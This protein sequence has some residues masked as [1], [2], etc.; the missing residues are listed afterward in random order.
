MPTKTKSR[1]E[2]FQVPIHKNLTREDVAG[3]ERIMRE[4][5]DKQHLGKF[6]SVKDITIR[7]PAVRRY[8]ECKGSEETYSGIFKVPV[9]RDLLGRLM[10]D[11]IPQI[12]ESLQGKVRPYPS[13]A[14]QYN[15]KNKNRGFIT[16]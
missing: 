3:I 7:T 10:Q 5:A 12:P 8:L 11:G 13:I 6:V 14:P 4:I 16:F 1:L 2:T 15:P 9:K